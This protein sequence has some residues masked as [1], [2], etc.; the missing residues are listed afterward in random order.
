MRIIHLLTGFVLLSSL[1]IAQ[2]SANSKSTEEPKQVPSFDV[3]ALDRSAE[4]CVNF[5]QFAC[6]NWMKNNPIPA[7]Q[8]SWG[9]FNELSERNRA[10]LREILESAAKA[11][12]R[13]AN[14]QKIGDYYAACMDEAGIN[15]KG[16]AVLAPE[17]DRIAALKDKSALPSLVAYLHRRQ[18]NAFFDLGSAPD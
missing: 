15:R 2:G 1:A 14:E 8:P 3:T 16:V 10:V 9:R 17:F 18:F 5:Y 11:T 12:Q 13:T 4:P 6:G 7:D